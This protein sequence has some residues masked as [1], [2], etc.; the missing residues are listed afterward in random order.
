MSRLD[1]ATS[2]ANTHLHSIDRGYGPPGG[3][4]IEQ[5][6][7]AYSPT[8]LPKVCSLLTWLG[9]LS[10]PQFGAHDEAHPWLTKHHTSGAPQWQVAC[11][12]PAFLAWV[13]CQQ[14]VMAVNETTLPSSVGSASHSPA[15]QSWASLGFGMG[16]PGCLLVSFQRQQSKWLSPCSSCSS[17]AACRLHRL[18]YS[19]TRLEGSKHLITQ[20]IQ[21]QAPSTKRALSPPHGVSLSEAAVI[22]CMHPEV[23][24]SCQKPSLTTAFARVAGIICI[25]HS[26]SG[27]ISTFNECCLIYPM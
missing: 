10:E 26:L 24:I 11:A 19:C 14:H 23:H 13:L 7:Q 5:E 15:Y 27:I 6:T 16:T 22:P 8:N 17:A 18:L 20:L 4:K 2:A 12:S 1:L 21:R 3:Q 25:T 9:H